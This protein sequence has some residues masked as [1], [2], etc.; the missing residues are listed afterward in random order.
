VLGLTHSTTLDAVTRFVDQVLGLCSGLALRSG[1]LEGFGCL[2]EG[3]AESLLPV[4]VR[5][6]GALLPSTLFGQG[7]H[8]GGGDQRGV[9][10]ESIT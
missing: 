6:A 4:H 9:V 1:F 5:A 2:G 8:H 3:V 10:T 7:C